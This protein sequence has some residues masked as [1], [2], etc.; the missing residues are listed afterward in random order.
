MIQIGDTNIYVGTRDDSRLRHD[1]DWAVVNTAKT[2]HC[3][4]MGWGS[5]TPKD[6]P[7][8]L[9]FEDGQLLSFNWVDGGSFLY[10][11]SGPKSFTRALDFIE[12]WSESKKILINC[13]QGQSRSPTVA[14]LYLAKRVHTVSDESF[15]QARTDFQALYPSYAPSGIADF[16]NTHW[17]EIN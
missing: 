9:S 10:K 17:T 13:D 11:M 1:P 6:H 7:N 4:I 16:V 3:E 5:A 14:L 2:V 15:A 8:Y 12:R